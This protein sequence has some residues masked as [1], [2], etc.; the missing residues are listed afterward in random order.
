MNLP[1]NLGGHKK[2]DGYSGP[3]LNED[4]LKEFNKKKVLK[5]LNDKI[6][7]RHVHNDIS[8][9]PASEL[10]L[11]RLVVPKEEEVFEAAQ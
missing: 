11:E 10:H 3:N 7:S 1:D 9:K 4:L 6:S 5:N 2:K 8:H